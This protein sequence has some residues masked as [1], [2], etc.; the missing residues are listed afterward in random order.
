MPATLRWVA[1]TNGLGIPD[2]YDPKDA[3]TLQ[4]VYMRMLYKGNTRAATECGR[5]LFSLSDYNGGAGWRM[6]RQAR[7]SAPGDYFVTSNINPGITAANQHENA[8]YPRRIFLGQSR[9]SKYGVLPC[10]PSKTE[11]AK[12]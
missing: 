6:R 8:T 12:N 4:A 3:L 11:N 10:Q 9:Y 5:W 7:S 1:A 2:P